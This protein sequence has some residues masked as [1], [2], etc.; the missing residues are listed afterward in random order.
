MH[1]WV[2]T[3]AAESVLFTL[4]V[5]SSVFLH[6]LGG[7]SALQGN[8]MLRSISVDLFAGPQYSAAT[9]LSNEFYLL[10]VSAIVTRMV[11]PFRKTV[12]HCC[13]SIVLA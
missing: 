10:E 13:T 2:G 1:M 5:I 3:L 4:S 6:S 11:F 9:V 7:A 8:R 12:V